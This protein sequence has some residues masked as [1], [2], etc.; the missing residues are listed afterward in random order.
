MCKRSNEDIANNNTLSKNIVVSE[1]FE[2]SGSKSSNVAT[3]RQFEFGNIT[4]NKGPQK[5]YNTYANDRWRRVNNSNKTVS[6]KADES[7]LPRESQI[8]RNNRSVSTTSTLGMVTGT[9]SEV[10]SQVA[11]IREKYAERIRDRDETTAASD[12]HSFQDSDKSEVGLARAPG[13]GSGGRRRRSDRSSA[14]TNDSSS[15]QNSSVRKNFNAVGNAASNRR[16]YS[17]Y[18]PTYIQ[19]VIEENRTYRGLS[20]IHI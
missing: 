10:S 19:P 9:K 7:T 14:Q 20:L 2:P 18:L 11:A 13:R 16:K 4:L 3:C 5:T 15:K 6:T 8:D 12:Q 17:P 1:I